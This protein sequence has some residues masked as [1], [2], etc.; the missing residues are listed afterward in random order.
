MD[1]VRIAPGVVD[2]NAALGNDVNAV[3]SGDRFVFHYYVLN[4]LYV[5]VELSTDFSEATV[6]NHNAGTNYD[7]SINIFRLDN[8]TCDVVADVSINNL[9]VSSIV[10]VQGSYGLN[11]LI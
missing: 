4:F 3:A 7:Q 10:S 9:V 2:A 11:Y 5:D 6:N 1:E 8:H